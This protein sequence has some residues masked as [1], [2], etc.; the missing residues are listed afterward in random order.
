MIGPLRQIMPL[1][2]PKLVRQWGLYGAIGAEVAGSVIGGLAVG[3]FLDK[4]LGISPVCTS[5]GLILGMGIATW[6][7]L[8]LAKKLEKEEE[9]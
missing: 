2:D 7:M 9:P 5:A 3:Y 6:R 1:L 8:Q 4:K